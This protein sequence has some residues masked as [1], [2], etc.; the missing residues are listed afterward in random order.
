MNYT[1]IFQDVV[2]CP[3]VEIYEGLEESA[4]FITRAPHSTCYMEA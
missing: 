4:A 3:L 1:Y 2:Q